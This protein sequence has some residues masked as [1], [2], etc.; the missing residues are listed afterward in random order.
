LS[1]PGAPS[2]LA[3]TPASATSV[4]LTWTN[5]AGNQTGFHLDRATDSGFTQNLITETLPPSPN[6]FTDVASG[7]APGTT[8]YYR[9][10]AF[11]SI[12]DSTSS[13]TASVTIPQLPPVATNPQITKV[14]TSEID[15]SWQDNA[16]SQATGYQ[17]LRAINHGALTQ[18]ATLPAGSQGWADTSV[19]S[20]TFYDYHII[21]YN[22]AGNT[23]FAD[24]SANSLTSAP[25]NVVASPSNASVT[26]SWAV[27]TGAVSYNIYRGSTAGGEGTTPIASSVT[28]T[29]FTDTGLT[30]GATYYYVVTALNGNSAPLP[31]ESARSNEVSATPQ[32][33]GTGINFANGFAGAQGLTLNGSAAFNGS[34]LELTNSGLHQA[35]SFFATSPVSVTKFTT[36]FTFQ[37]SA[38]SNIADGFTFTIQGIGPTALGP[39]GG[40]LGYGPD[41]AGNPPGIGKSVAIKFDLYNNQ[42]EGSDSTGLYTN[43][44][45]PTSAG[46]I[47]LTNT[48]I[49]LHSGDVFQVTMTYDG[50]TLVVTIH[51]TVTGTSATQNYAINIP[52]VVGGNQ[53]YVGFTG[54]T[55]GLVATQ[56][57]LSWTYTPQ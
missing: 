28:T 25:G 1:A 3:A 15:L 52:S 51:D 13:N 49:N 5:N 20:G 9:L 40:G 44:Q 53:A 34:K 33:A 19:S 45:A 11:N 56:D 43:G 12:G 38:G 16:G 22:A 2:G 42:G 39:Q 54:G 35:G 46:S 6:S 7:L 57:I 26:L 55:G 47:D 17:I 18:V 36:T 37:L 14:T 31:A 24:V 41:T 48:G 10:R 29:N 50:T 21:A 30:N 32:A 27:P 23:G 4:N 8:F